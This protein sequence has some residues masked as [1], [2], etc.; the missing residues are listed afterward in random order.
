[1]SPSIEKTKNKYLLLDS[2]VIEYWLDTNKEKIIA[3]QIEE[4]TN[5]TATIA[6]SEITALELIDGAHKIKEKQVLEFLNKLSNFST[7][8]RVILG[9]GKLGSLYY[10]TDHNLKNSV[11]LG[12]KIIASTSIIY[13][14]PIATA[15]VKDFPYPFFITLSHKNLIYENKNKQNMIC[16]A[17][18]RP[19]YEFINLKFKQRV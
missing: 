6:I 8:D 17:I 2:C 9:A 11:S 19:N 12:D 13:N 14:L 7:T 3:K 5:N 18:L 15:N 4:W 10:Q 16:L 1:M